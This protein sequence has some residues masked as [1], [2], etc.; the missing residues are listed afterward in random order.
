[1]LL[2]VIVFLHLLRVFLTGAYQK[3][4]H[5]NWIA[6]LILLAFVIFSNFTGYLLPW[7]QLAY[8]AITVSTSI[9][10]YIPLIGDNL[11]ELV[12]AGNEVNA[13]TLLIFYN[14][15][16]SVLPI[17]IFLLMAYHFWRVRKA[18]GVLVPDNPEESKIVP[19]YPNLV[20]KEG[21]AA[22]VLIAVLFTLAVFFNAP[23]L[24]T[25]N[26]NYSMNPTKAPWYFAGI[27]ELLLHFHP[28]FAGFL[29]PLSAMVL[30]AWL[31][32]LKYN[33]PA[34]GKWFQSE[35]GKLSAKYSAIFGL[36]LTSILIF[37][38]EFLLNFE[39]I[40]PWL[41]AFISNGIIP[42]LLFLGILRVYYKFLK[43][44]FNLT[45]TESVQA[46]FILMITAFITLTLTGIFF[47]D[48]NMELTFPWN[49]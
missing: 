27:Q 43:Q 12:L 17:L 16:T 22:A 45:K 13:D 32:F 1:V 41:P 15:H 3:P 4:R 35:R 10:Q 31:P 11:R 8:W 40:L 30:I 29:I 6:G 2:V 49:F 33:K 5:V 9:L 46:I 14:F 21:V 20:Y 28:F 23:L 36:I 42:L 25:A 44:K 19:V 39:T 37:I 26:P 18:G 24:E 38:S 34:A 47:R 48:V 7:D